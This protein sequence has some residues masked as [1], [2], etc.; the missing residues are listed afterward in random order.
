MTMSSASS[1]WCGLQTWL[2]CEILQ[3]CQCSPDYMPGTRTN[4]RT[5]SAGLDAILLAFSA[6]SHP[7]SHWYAQEK[8]HTM[9]SFAAYA[10]WVKSVHFCE[11][12]PQARVRI[13]RLW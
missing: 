12:P 6:I 13:S 3:R 8:P 11:P 7:R 4:G 10:D 1:P 2:S 9:K 5:L